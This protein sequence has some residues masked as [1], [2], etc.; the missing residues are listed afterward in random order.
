[1]D[2]QPPSSLDSLVAV[3]VRGPGEWIVGM[4]AGERSLHVYQLAPDDWLVSEVG[5]RNEGRATDLKQAIVALSAGGSI[6]DW[7]SVVPGMLDGR[8]DRRSLRSS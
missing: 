8:E 4:P 1:V 3:D 2:R 7:W 5:H 6:P